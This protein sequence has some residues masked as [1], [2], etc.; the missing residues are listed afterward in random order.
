VLA[1][2]A[3]GCRNSGGRAGNGLSSRSEADQTGESGSHWL[4]VRL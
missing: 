3:I 2:Y 4:T 1:L